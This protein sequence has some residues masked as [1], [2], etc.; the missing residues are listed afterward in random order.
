M[1]FG[2]EKY[3][4]ARAV[5]DVMVQAVQER[6]KRIAA[7][8]QAILKGMLNDVR[9]VIYR[10]KALTRDLRVHHSLLHHST[11]GKTDAQGTSFSSVCKLTYF[12]SRAFGIGKKAFLIILSGVR[13]HIAGETLVVESVDL[14]V[15]YDP[16]LFPLDKDSTRGGDMRE[17]REMLYN[18]V[19]GNLKVRLRKSLRSLRLANDQFSPQQNIIREVGARI[20]LKEGDIP[21]EALYGK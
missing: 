2:K 3:I 19:P 1:V 18:V 13:G 5:S 9:N 17:V 15:F 11:M 14:K 12:G 21:F 8:H 10:E 20:N 6:V 4:Y 7:E 16:F